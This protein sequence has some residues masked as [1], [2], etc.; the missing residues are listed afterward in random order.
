MALV[1]VGDQSACPGGAWA[2]GTKVAGRT[3][4][5][6]SAPC[7]YRAF[8]AI[9]AVGEGVMRQPEALAIGPGGRVYV[10]DQLTH[11][12]QMFSAS[13]RF[14]G[15]WGSFG[16]GPGQFGAVGGLA[17]NAAGDV[18]LVDCGGDRI[19][20]FTPQGRL[21]RSFGDRGGGVGEFDF[22]AGNGPSEPP[23]GG[24]AVS[25]R[26][27]FVS[28]TRNN[29]I[30]RFNLDGGEARVIAPPGSRPGQVMHPNGLAVAPA[31]GGA[32]ETLYVADDG[33]DRVQALSASGRFLGAVARFPAQPS[34]FQNPFDVAVHGDR[35]Y[36]VDDNHGRIVVFDRALRYLS[37]FGGEGSLHLTP[38]I[39]SVAVASSGVT[40]VADAHA[41]EVLIFDRE[42]HPIGRFGISTNDA[43]ELEDPVDV[44]LR[45][46]GSGVAVEPYAGF[47]HLAG[48]SV[49]AP[50]VS[51]SSGGNVFLGSLWF[52]PAG[53]A[54][55]R[56]GTLWA[57]DIN[58]S[59]VR[60]LDYN[61]RFLAAIGD[62]A[63]AGAPSAITG[64]GYA[65]PSEPGSSGGPVLL[66]HL[67]EPTGVAVLSDGTVIVA[68]TGEGALLR[69][70]ASGSVLFRLR[71]PVGGSAFLRPEALAAGPS[72]TFYLADP[73]AQEIE[74][75][76]AGGR[77]L[78]S[79]RDPA[80]AQGI[81]DAAGRRYPTGLAV[82]A[83]GSVFVSDGRLGRIEER[84]P[85]GALLALLGSE[86]SGSGQLSAP[87]G[88]AINCAGD[89][90]VADT[91]NNRLA[92]FM[93]AARPGCPP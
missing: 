51:W 3:I 20:E 8:R 74:Q 62:P 86:G 13:G 52:S 88:L 27:I 63:G 60:H 84:S 72:D 82:G 91:G 37:A 6:G 21:L 33:N 73:G 14:E 41:N 80:I 10:G 77:L 11:K 18:Y 93:G 45:P 55:A 68:D 70:S 40:Y 54:F 59:V 23:G 49:L 34:Q 69:L 9:G 58:N 50:T 61:G 26:Y 36:V 81:E 85:S 32:P 19:E 57:S 89:L 71:A 48:F 44:A 2:K 5:A 29:R 90:F 35:V 22:G 83:E 17:S 28:D 42:G 25:A 43:G 66:A 46:D 76:S 75:L 53:A 39:R 7:P 78:A 38:F 87:G 67:L 1:A 15:Q 92:V 16:T 31:Q 64:R 30:E 4:S 56:D 24:I 65:A 79:W 12:V 47:L